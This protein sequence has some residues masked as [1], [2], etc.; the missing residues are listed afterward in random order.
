MPA[1]P[2][3]ALGY[4]S[5]E[6]VMNLARV[7]VNDAFAGAT[8]TPGEGRTFT[9]AAPFTIPI[10]NSAVSSLARELE[11]N[12]VTTFTVDN[13]IITIPPVTTVDPGIQ[14]SLLYSGYFN[15]TTNSSSPSLPADL[16]MPLQIWERPTGSTMAFKPMRF[17]GILPSYAQAE[18]LQLWTWNQDQL[19]FLGAIQSMDIRLRYKSR[20]LPK[21]TATTNF[22]TTVIGCADSADALAYEAAKIYAGARNGVGLSPSFDDN[23]KK[24]VNGMILRYV[25]AQQ[26]Q[27]NQRIPYGD[28]GAD[29]PGENAESW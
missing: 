3:T 18:Y 4:P 5:I 7:L 11:N 9:D 17:V 29:L 16:Q 6:D 13:F 22:K 10:L 20:I 8:G 24:A 27:T 19:N 2:T 15:G 23:H 12:G 26:E 21:I 14:A 28:S 1:V 25:R